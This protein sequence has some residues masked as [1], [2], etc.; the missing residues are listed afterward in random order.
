M[1]RNERTRTGS[2]LRLPLPRLLLAGLALV[3]VAAGCAGGGGG[4]GPSGGALYVLAPDELHYGASYGAWGARWWQ[5]CMEH[6]VTNHPLFDTTGA[7]ALE[8]Q[9]DPVWFLGG[10]MVTVLAPSTGFAERSVTIPRGIALFFPIINTEI[11]NGYCLPPDWGTKSITE[12]R[13]FAYDSVNAVQDV[14]CEVDG[15]SIIDSPDLSGAIRY[16]AISPQFSAFI[17]ADNIGAAMCGDPAVARL[18][19]PIASDGIWMMLEPMPPGE[20]EI[21]FGGTFPIPV[22][23]HLD[24]IYHITVTP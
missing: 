6:P 9:V 14:Y 18:I 13:Q 2:W 8:D 16:R 23:F 15:A 1:L 19:D 10:V 22:V 12:M 3:L 5:W 20:H 4:G 11:D 21:R 17:P 24:I 7:D